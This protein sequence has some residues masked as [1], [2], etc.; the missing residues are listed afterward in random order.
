M[1]PV[2]PT[3]SLQ[4]KLLW[5]TTLVTCLV[6]AAVVVVVEHRQRAAVIDEAHRRG[7]ILARDLAAVSHAPLLL[8]NFT[9]LEQ[10]VAR[11]HA[12]ALLNEQAAHDAAVAVL[13]GLA[14]ARHDDGAGG[15]DGARQRRDRR[16]AAEA[17]EEQH[18][19]PE[20]RTDLA[21]EAAAQPGCVRRRCA[22]FH[23]HAAF[24]LLSTLRD[25]AA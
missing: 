15:H 16:P 10:N 20:T 18:D 22:Q 4:T 7:Q 1:N 19:D 14:V 13:H 17:A 3:R 5:G 2:F 6:M 25:G 8:Y 12:L 11:R 23:G 24:P 9:S 21:L